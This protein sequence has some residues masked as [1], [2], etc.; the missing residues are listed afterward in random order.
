MKPTMGDA[1][2]VLAFWL[3]EI[4][5]GGWYVASDTVDEAIRQ[6]F[7]TLVEDALAGGLDDWR[8]NPRG[9]LALLILLDQFTRNLYR[10]DAKAFAG[11]ARARDIA[12]DAVARNIDLEI[13]PPG[14]Q[15]FYMP[16][17]HS[18][19]LADQD[20][21]VALFTARMTLG[22]EMMWHIE[23]HRDLIRRFGRFPYRNA[24]LD[25]VSTPEE[26]AF[27]AEGGYRPGTGEDESA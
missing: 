23:Q 6:R 18:E 8:S 16:F 26:E 22:D 15:F 17:E 7:G 25:R 4:G 3:D 11:D 9:T 1:D 27:L 21:S 13:E 2:A 20:W 14:R 12:R 19:D 10:G 5:P 24:A